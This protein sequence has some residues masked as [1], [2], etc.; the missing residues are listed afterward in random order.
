MIFLDSN[1][2]LRFI[3]QDEDPASI[4]MVRV[5][6]LLFDAVESGALEV[7]TNDVVIHEV[8]YMLTARV[9]Y[10]LPVGRVAE[11]LSVI[12]RQ[13]GFRLSAGSKRRCLR[14][15]EVWTENPVLGFADALIVASVEETDIAL[16]TFDSHFNRIPGITRWTPDSPK[17]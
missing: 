8:A 10:G 16:A 6:K 11:Q 13:P 14:A 7:T 17:K 12:L 5:A 2:F 4:E 9:G 1:Y 3:A 15:L